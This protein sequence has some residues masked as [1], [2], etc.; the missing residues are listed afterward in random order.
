MSDD[1]SDRESPQAAQD[2]AVEA[3]ATRAAWVPE[4][5]AGMLLRDLVA[6]MHGAGDDAEERYQNALRQACEDPDALLVEVARALGDC[7]ERDYALR[8]SLVYTAGQLKNPAS[9]PLLK[10]VVT[11]PIPPERSRDPHS[12]STVAEDTALRTTAVEGV[13]ALARDGDEQATR[14]LLGFLD[15]DSI[16][17]RR[18]AVQGLLAAPNADDLRDEIVD[19]L[20][21]AQRFLLDVKPMNVTDVAQIS[22]P[23]AHLSER[24]RAAEK[25]QPPRVDDSPREIAKEHGPRIARSAD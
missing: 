4:T 18:S 11:T 21:K 9:L 8:W 17:I 5:A 23:T 22:D 3:G 25:E 13:A 6:T 14:A 24:G 15:I 12:F 19:C 1:N 16:S 2:D 20:P 10:T 7:S